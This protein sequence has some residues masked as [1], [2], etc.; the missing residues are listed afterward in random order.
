MSDHREN[1]TSRTPNGEV[2]DAI[3]RSV[4]RAYNQVAEEPIPDS[5]QSLL[6]K[7]RQGGSEK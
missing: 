3:S 4:K 1:N 5:I 2:D 6:E 7:L